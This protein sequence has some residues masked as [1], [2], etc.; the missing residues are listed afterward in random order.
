MKLVT[1]TKTIQETLHRETGAAAR[2]ERKAKRLTALEV[3]RRMKVTPSYVCEL[4][5]GRRDWNEDLEKL[6]NDALKGKNA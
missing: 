6:Y 4:E 2:K 3:S 1:V 5:K